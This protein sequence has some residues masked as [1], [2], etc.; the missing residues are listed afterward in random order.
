MDQSQPDI[1]RA[2]SWQIAGVSVRL[3][4]S[5]AI[6]FAGVLVASVPF[7]LVFAKRC[8]D[9]LGTHLDR[10]SF[11][12]EMSCS[13][14]IVSSIGAFNNPGIEFIGSAVMVGFLRRRRQQAAAR[15]ETE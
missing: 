7:M 10:F 14:Q 11:H 8:P 9:L 5:L 6:V 12:K 15:R 1:R 4:G 2:T 13:G 3:A